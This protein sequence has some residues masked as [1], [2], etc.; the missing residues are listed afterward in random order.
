MTKQEIDKTAIAVINTNLGFIKEDISE[1]KN[2]LKGLPA[3]FASKEEL[4]VIAK[5]TEL[6]LTK[7]EEKSNSVLGKWLSPTIAYV[8]GTILTFLIVQYFVHCSQLHC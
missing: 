5:E 7:L 6:R 2:S 3:I 1:I 8:L 4:V